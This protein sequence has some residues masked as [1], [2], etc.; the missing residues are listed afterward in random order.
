MILRYDLI[1]RKV[2]MAFLKLSS[3]TCVEARIAKGLPVFREAGCLR[4][5]A[6]SKEL[7]AWVERKRA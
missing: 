5:M 3:W 4:W 2:I 7:A 6:C 1:G